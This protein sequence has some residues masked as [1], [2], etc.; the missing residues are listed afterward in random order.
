MCFQHK[1]VVKREAVMQVTMDTSTAMVMG[2]TKAL[3]PAQAMTL[4]LALAATLAL[5]TPAQELALSRAQVS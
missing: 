4:A 3:A 2:T 5:A 1:S